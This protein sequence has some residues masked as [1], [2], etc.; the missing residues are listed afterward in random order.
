MKSTLEELRRVIP[1]RA[2]ATPRKVLI[3]AGFEWLRTFSPAIITSAVVHV[4]GAQGGAGAIGGNS[5]IGGT[6]GLGVSASGTLAVTPGST[7]KIF[8]GG[9]GATPTGAFNGGANG[10]SQNANAGGGAS[11]IRVGGVGGGRVGCHEGSGGVNGAD[12]VLSA[13]VAAGGKGA[14]DAAAGVVGVGCGGF[15]GAAGTAAPDENGGGST[16]SG[17]STA[18]TTAQG[19]NLGN[20][21]VEVCFAAAGPAP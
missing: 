9:Q 17:A 5:V 4:N 12:S 13:G 15:L 20:G 19:L 8:L 16:N 21:S 1:V 10:G 2:G 14:V 6:G 18:A 7:L 11:D 3:V